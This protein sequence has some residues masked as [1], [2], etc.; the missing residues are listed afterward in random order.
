MKRRIYLRMKCLNEARDELLSRFSPGDLVGEEEISSENAFGR[1]SSRPVFAK[2]SSPT[3]HSAAMDGYAVRAESTFGATDETPLMLKLGKEAV[4]INTGFPMPEDKNAVVMVEHAILDKGGEHIIIRSPVFPWQNVRKVGEDIVKTELVFPSNHLFA[5]YDIGALLAS[6]NKKIWVWRRPKLKIIPTG[7][8]LISIEELSEKE[9]KLKK[10]FTIESNSSVLSALCKQA[11][12]IYEKTPIVPDEPDEIKRAIVEAVNSDA[13]IILINAGSSAGSADYTANIIE[14]LGQVLVH[15]ITVMPGKPT[16][17]G[18]VSGKPVIGIPGYPVSAIV[19]FEQIVEPLIKRLVGL[20]PKRPVKVNGI[21]CRNLPS[22]SGMEEFRRV[23]AG[24]V[25]RN[26]VAT[27][28]KKGAGSITTI[29]KANAMLRIP[30]EV[31]GLNEGSLVELELLRPW[32]NIERTLLCVGSHDLTLDLIAD[33]LK[34]KTLPVHMASSHVGSL[35]GI[36]SVSKGLCHFC[37]T[38]LLDAQSGEYNISYVK[39]HA[40][41][42]RAVLINLVYRQ[43]GFIVQK[44]NPKGIRDFS[45]LLQKDITFINRQKGSGTRVLF[46]YELEKRGINPGLINGYSSE[47][48]THMA[49]AVSV[50]SKKAD[51]GL[52]ILSAAKALDLDFV[53]VVEERYDLL[54]PKDFLE[55]EI[56]KA[57]IDVISTDK[58]K[59]SA[60]AL[61]GYSLRHCGK[62]MY[63]Q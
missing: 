37:G 17:I 5:P 45:D 8:E 26:L 42:L 6:G 33:F 19:A 32:Q 56:I 41:N 58:F 35:G 49:V 25:G 62:V 48:Y 44:G 50:L 13:H 60:E 53:P 27:P 38:H 10:G 18:L 61:G 28:I 22:R 12:G 47:E 21:L 43:Q 20:E 57:L 2:L 31:E 3:F 4:P 39:K 46:D 29:T 9:A 23:I 24:R 52:G 16:I 15:G 36:I 54:I 40:P 55:L 11:G 59:S 7:S 51:V 34:R 63:E 14:S 30:L 1:V